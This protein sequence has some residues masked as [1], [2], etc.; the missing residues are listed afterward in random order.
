MYTPAEVRVRVAQSA[1]PV[2]L[3][4]QILAAFDAYIHDAK[5][6]MQQTSQKSESFLWSDCNPER[7]QEVR[8]SGSG[9]APKR[10][11]GVERS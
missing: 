6:E 8:E 3:S 2:E 4:P 1:K 11:A 7:A 5:A 9:Q 10:S